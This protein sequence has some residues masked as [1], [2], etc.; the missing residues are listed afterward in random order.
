MARVLAYIDFRIAIFRG[1]IPHFTCL[2][3]MM[4]QETYATNPAIRAAC[5]AG[6]RRRG[7]SEPGRG[8]RDGKCRRPHRPG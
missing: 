5:E 3:G 7:I 1:A 2:L 6:I 4:V 8:S